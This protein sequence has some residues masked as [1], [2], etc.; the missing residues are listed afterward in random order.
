ML[1]GN[2]KNK[3]QDMFP[4][5]TLACYELVRNPPRHKYMMVS[6]K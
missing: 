5:E 6:C 4:I 2:V 3:S 1:I